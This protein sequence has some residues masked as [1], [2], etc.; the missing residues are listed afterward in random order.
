MT[1]ITCTMLFTPRPT[2]RL[3]LYRTQAAAGRLSICRL[4]AGHT[5]VLDGR[6]TPVPCCSTTRLISTINSENADHAFYYI[7]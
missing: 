5:L 4:A 2:T 7:V 1:G 6:H 3:S